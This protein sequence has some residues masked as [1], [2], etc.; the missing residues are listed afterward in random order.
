MNIDCSKLGEFVGVSLPKQLS[1]ATC[2]AILFR[3]RYS[4]FSS[5]DEIRGFARKVLP[6]KVNPFEKIP[7]EARQKIDD[8][9]VIRNYLSHQVHQGIL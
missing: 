8:A 1:L 7:K 2:Q 9:F 3:E 4:D 5:V 6:D